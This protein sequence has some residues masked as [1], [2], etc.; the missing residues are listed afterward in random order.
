V[1]VDEQ[2]QPGRAPRFPNYPDTP[3]KAAPQP[4]EHT[5]EVLAEWLTAL[6]TAIAE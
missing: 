4:G 3:I 1:F 2:L 5:D 6:P